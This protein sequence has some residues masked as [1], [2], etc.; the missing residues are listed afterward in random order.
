MKILAVS[1]AGGHFAELKMI[2]SN[3][4][5]E[6]DITIITEDKVSDESVDYFIPYS[7]RSNK[8]K[9]IIDFLKNMRLAYKH[10]KI[11]NPDKIISTGAHN[12]F[13]YFLIGKIFFKTT[14]IYVESFAK[15]EAKSLTYKISKHFIDTN[16]VQH[17]KMMDVEPGSEYFGGVY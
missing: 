13:Y 5:N 4:S 17:E 14:N 3:L 2:T 10:L 11:I 8:L 16:I 15:V 1:S 6:F 9:Y 7:T 12:A